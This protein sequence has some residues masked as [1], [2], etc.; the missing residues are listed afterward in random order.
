MTPTG[1]ADTDRVFVD[2]VAYNSKWYY[3]QGDVAAPGRMPVTGYETVLD[4]INFAGGLIAI[5]DPKNV[6]LVRPA[7]GGK[8]ARTY[9]IDWPAIVEKG[10]AAANLQLFP[11]DRLVVGRSGLVRSTIAVDRVA[12]P[13]QTFL[14]SML[15]ASFMVRSLVTATPDLTPSQREALV[16]DS[17]D[18]F[19]QATRTPAGEVDEKTLRELVLKQL[20]PVPA[21][22]PKTDK[23]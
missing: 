18:L 22:G 17:F 20:R 2:V 1:P 16:R 5:S 23:K 14:H 15:S 12:A 8:P 4:A 19:W 21:A 9:P 6:R 13:F 10:D 7:R 3:V 11:G